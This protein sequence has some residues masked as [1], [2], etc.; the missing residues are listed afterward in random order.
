MQSLTQ[1]ITRPI[2]TEKSSAMKAEANKIAFVVARAANKIEIKKAVEGLF[3]VKVTNVQTMVVRGKLKRVGKSTGRRKNWKKA[4]VTL[5][6]GT[7]LDVFGVDLG[8]PIPE[9]DE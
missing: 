3:E 7:D 4:I 9:G 5:E 8:G 1:V 6:P 2:L